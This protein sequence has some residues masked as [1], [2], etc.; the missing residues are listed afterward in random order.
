MSAASKEQFDKTVGVF[1]CVSF[2]LCVCVCVSMRV[3]VVEALMNSRGRT[4]TNRGN[5]TLDIAVH[6]RHHMKNVP[7]GLLSVFYPI[8]QL[9]SNIYFTWP[10]QYHTALWYLTG[11]CLLL[12]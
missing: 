6:S 12:E 5:Q 10:S 9:N 4:I 11:D 2:F 7:A 3:L 1:L 8:T